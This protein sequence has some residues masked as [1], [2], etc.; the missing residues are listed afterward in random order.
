MLPLH[1]NL[2]CNQVF[3]KFWFQTLCKILQY[4]WEI[5]K[6][7]ILKSLSF[8]KKNLFSCFFEMSAIGVGLITV[9]I[10]KLISYFDASTYENT[11]ETNISQVT[12]KN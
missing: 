4:T 6:V 7:Q 11:T 12:L 5:F 3:R 1:Q 10:Y 8:I 2:L 9:P